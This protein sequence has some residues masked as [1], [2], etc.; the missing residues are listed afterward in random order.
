[1]FVCVWAVKLSFVVASGEL[2]TRGSGVRD[3]AGDVELSAP[4]RRLGD[5]RRLFYGRRAVHEDPVV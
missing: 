5:M 4:S 3:P 2:C 1:M